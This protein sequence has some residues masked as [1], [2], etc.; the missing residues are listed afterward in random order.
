MKKLLLTLVALATFAT[1]SLTARADED[2]MVAMFKNATIEQKQDIIGELLEMM[3]AE[4][5]K[6][7]SSPMKRVWVDKELKTAVF[8]MNM[9]GETIDQ[10]NKMPMIFKA[11]ILQAMAE[12][13]EMI[14]VLKMI[15]SSQLGLDFFLQDPTNENKTA[16]VE[17]TADELMNLKK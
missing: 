2:E 15:G 9:D 11:G 4:I 10:A 16:I 8:A 1:C 7:A 14:E 6:D 13:D 3:N 17:V 5:S 12:D